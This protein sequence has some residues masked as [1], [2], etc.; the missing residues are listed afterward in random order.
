MANQYDGNS[1][2][3]NINSEKTTLVRI[4]IPV[5]LTFILFALAVFFLFIPSVEKQM[6]E[7]KRDMIRSLTDTVWGLI[8]EYNKDVQEGRF[9]L[10]DGQAR[11]IRRLQSMRYGPELKNY[12]WINDMHP[13][14][15]MHPYRSDLVGKDLTQFTDTNGKRLFAAFVKKVQK[16]KSG[17]VD[18]MWQMKN[19]DRMIPKLSYVKAFEP[20]GWVVGTGINVEDVVDEIGA[21]EKRILF[22][23]GGLF[24][25]LSAL[26]FYVVRESIRFGNKR[27][28]AEKNL[29]ESESRFRTLGEDAPFGISIM[30]SD[31]RFEYLNP[32]F[33]Q[34]FGY[35]IEDIPDKTRWFEKAYPNPD[36][37]E[38]VASSWKKDKEDSNGSTEIKPRIYTVHCKNGEDKI[39]HF[40]AVH[41]ESN[42]QLITY[43]D[44]SD[45]ARA[46]DAVRKSERNF[47]E[48]YEASRKSEEL[49]RSLLHS[50]ADAIV[51]YDMAGLTQYVS[52]A[53]TQIFGWAL[54]EVT[55]RH[56]P[57][58]PESEKGRTMKVALDLAEKG[59]PC[60][61]FQ[62][63]RN[64]KDG[65]TLHVSISASRYAD[66]EGN[67]GGM[68]VILRDISEMKELEAQFLQ[69][70]KME[71]IGTL[72][73]GVAHDF[74]NLLMAI[75][76]NVSLLL[77]GKSPEHPDHAWLKKIEKCVADG[78]NLTRQMLG[79][80]R[81][82]K[83]AVETTD[84][85]SL[86]RNSIDLFGSTKKE[87]S[88]HSEYE[89]DLMASHVDRGQIEQVLMNIFVNA[90]HAMPGGGELH[91]KTRNIVL[92]AA[93]TAPYD[94][95]PGKHVKIAVRDT[96][97][98][99]HPENLKRI[100]D[101]FFT[102]K[103]V[104]RG[105]GLGLASAYGIVRNHDGFITVESEIGKGTEFCIYLPAVPSTKPSR[106]SAQKNEDLFVHGEG[107]ILLVDDEDI[108][109]EV[110]VPILETLGYQ[111]KVAKNGTEAL[112]TY[113]L[114]GNGIDLVILDMIMPD[115]S[116][117][118]VFDRLKAMNADV[119]VLLASGYSIDG[120][121]AGIMAR[122]CS[123]FI[124]KPFIPSKLSCLL[125]D[126]LKKTTVRF[127]TSNLHVNRP[128]RANRKNHLQ[129]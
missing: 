80:A 113:R 11:V 56:I 43:E 8:S 120:P 85:N 84:L 98:G 109:L 87:I 126:L 13:T 51:I 73:G 99:I 61:G 60:R 17:Y 119:K 52:P 1:A 86:L 71:S 22:L 110:G 104:G 82:G 122:G 49:Y 121:A 69:A 26:S 89:P 3:L 64:T 44:I 94:A 97:T 12:F 54:E 63:K 25:L 70:Q 20:W 96:G 10:E 46:E 62:T 127:H 95:Q 105:T 50:S 74:N 108:I 90:S 128:S 117:S 125:G 21:I 36:Y 15:I 55:G 66:H 124:Q 112:E 72:A 116:G 123:G 40:R 48:L 28:I 6:M 65:R 31:L 102:T 39:I 114:A 37:R 75:Q 33:T 106:K 4:I 100:F 14:M 9:S 79:F 30:D 5:A 27:R 58:L 88:I 68:L 35:T 32:N 118:E 16:E 129:Q 93:F 101:P 83:Y 115:M 76:G 78:A 59:I 103:E 91:I 81:G 41:L 19:P 42:R 23:S 34:I 107:T 92:D 111:V 38:M 53:F 7:Q 45:R 67:P 18:Y 57:F 47:M 2:I 77:M 29:M 24:L